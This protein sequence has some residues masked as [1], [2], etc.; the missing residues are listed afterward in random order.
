[1][2]HRLQHTMRHAL[3]SLLLL[4]SAYGGKAIAQDLHSVDWNLTLLRGKWQFH[5]YYDK[6]TLEFDCDHKM[7]FD[8]EPADYSLLSDTL[9]IQGNDGSTDYPYTIDGDALMLK[10]PDGS[11]RTYRRTDASD[12]E[13]KLHGDY[14]A[15]AG[16]SSSLSSMSFDGDH[17]AIIY[18]ISSGNKVSNNGIYRVEGDMIVLTYDD[19]TSYE[20]QIRSRDDGGVVQAVMFN[21]QQFQTEQA[22]ASAPREQLPV[23]SAPPSPVLLAPNYDVPQIPQSGFVNDYGYGGAAIQTPASPSTG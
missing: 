19:T 21:D 20:G 9:R 6:W 12:A 17:S 3:L 18:G 22:V 4:I 7:L 13:Q 1:M 10:L 16:S 11:E 5:T 23:A 8:R 14:Y 2:I 15:A